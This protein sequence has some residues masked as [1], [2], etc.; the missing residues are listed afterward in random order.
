MSIN[1]TGSQYLA[2]TP[3]TNVAHF[4]VSM[5]G[6]YYPTSISGTQTFF[7]ISDNTTNTDVFALWLNSFNTL[8]L[9]AGATTQ[10]VTVSS[11]VNSW[12]QL[13][14]SYNDVNHI[15][16]LYLD[17]TLI[18][19]FTYS[20]NI[21][22]SVNRVITFGGDIY[23]STNAITK[24]VSPFY[25]TAELPSSSFMAYLS[26]DSSF[27]GT[28]DDL[29]SFWQLS[30]VTDLSDQLSQNNL[31]IYGTGASTSFDPVNYVYPQ[32]A[33]SITSK[34]TKT[35]SLLN[36]YEM[37]AYIGP[38]KYQGWDEN[39]VYKGS[40]Y[41]INYIDWI[42]ISSFCTGKLDIKHTLE[43]TQ[44]T[45][46]GI[47]FDG[48]I[49][50]SDRSVLIKVHFY[51][52]ATKTWGLWHDYYLGYIIKGTITVD[53]H[54]NDWSFDLEG[55]YYYL[56]QTNAQDYTFGN[57]NVAKGKS[58][59]A[60]SELALYEAEKQTEG[61]IGTDVTAKMSTD[62][63]LSTTWISDGVPQVPTVQ[64]VSKPYPKINQTMWPRTSAE[65]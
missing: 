31:N 44:A 16:K 35:N 13:A 39:N 45:L 36:G 10:T 20:G 40:N 19:S 27:I 65:D 37:R 53:W 25:F 50:V 3:L 64:P 14:A 15:A 49:M 11:L 33:E 32:V 9:L 63:N 38:Y 24:L 52:A 12:H 28:E 61:F 26:M 29:Y 48:S 6:M 54:S 17:G 60:T 30:T 1:L 57:L 43:S 34:Q 18:L 23:T 4:E 51:D 2:S 7:T 59:S 21:V 55:D 22:N 62:G 5:G 8:H 56:N 58:A 47:N 42:D 46:T 41:Q